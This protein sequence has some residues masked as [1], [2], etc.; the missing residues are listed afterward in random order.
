MPAANAD[1]SVVDD[2]PR[3]VL[4]QHEAAAIINLHA[5]AVTVQN[6]RHLVPLVL[7]VTS[8]NFPRWC[9]AF[10]LTLGKY[11]LQN[12]VFSAA[13]ALGFLDWVQMDCVVRSWLV[14]TLS[15]ELAD[16]VMEH[17]ATACAT[18]LALESQF[19]GN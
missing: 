12:H 13:A 14:G 1:V 4:L 11:S 18:W 19:L 2:I 17:G 10:L 3:E 5:Q 8:T 15:P 6:I 16:V 9:E 7:D